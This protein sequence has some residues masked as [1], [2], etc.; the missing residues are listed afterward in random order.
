MARVIAAIA[1]NDS[2]E[3]FTGLGVRMAHGRGFAGTDEEQHAPIAVLSYNY[4]TRRFSRA[5]GVLGSTLFV[6]GVPLTIVGITAA[7]FE[8]T[9][10]GTSVDFWIP[11]QSRVELNA[12][13]D[14]ATDGKPYLMRQNWWCL[15]LLARPR[16]RGP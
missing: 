8:G 2:Q 3:R 12:W 13:G 6:R 5:P 1:P 7:G 14:P 11:L 10:P 4:W 9:E 16:P 15:R